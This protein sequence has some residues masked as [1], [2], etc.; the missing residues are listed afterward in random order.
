ME[1]SKCAAEG[2][3]PPAQHRRRLTARPLFQRVTLADLAAL[4]G[5][6]AVLSEDAGL[7]AIAAGAKGNVFLARGGGRVGARR[8][9]G[10]GR[11]GD[12][13]HRCAAHE[14]RSTDPE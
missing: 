10:D 9:A 8:I 4:F 12:V 14:E 7:G 13:L 5:D 11:F 2:G 1:T 3:L 6:A